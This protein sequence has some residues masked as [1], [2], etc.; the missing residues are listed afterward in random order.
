MGPTKKLSLDLN[1]GWIQ[2]QRKGELKFAMGSTSKFKL[3]F[4]SS[5]KSFIPN[6]IFCRGTH[7]FLDLNPESWIQLRVPNT[8]KEISVLF[9]KKIINFIMEKKIINFKVNYTDTSFF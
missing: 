8:Q 3:K 2:K 4:E 1:P 6:M 9:F 7:N 5:F